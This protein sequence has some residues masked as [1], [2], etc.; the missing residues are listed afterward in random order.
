MPQVGTTRNDLKQY[1]FVISNGALA[2]LIYVIFAVIY[3][4]NL[5]DMR[6]QHRVVLLIRNTT[7]GS[8]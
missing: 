4:A 5:P 2:A 6:C 1:F 7:P 8:G 3:S